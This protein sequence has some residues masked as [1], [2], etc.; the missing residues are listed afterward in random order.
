M[1]RTKRQLR[2]DSE[3]FVLFDEVN[4]PIV[5][6]SMMEES[7]LGEINLNA[8]DYKINSDNVLELKIREKK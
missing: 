6:L 7:G 2:F 1:T 3:Y 8:F 4:M 5:D